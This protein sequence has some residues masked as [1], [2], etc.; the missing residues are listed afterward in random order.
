MAMVTTPVA[1]SIVAP[2]PFTA[3]VS[4]APAK[5]A[6]AATAT[7]AAPASAATSA[8]GATT[9]GAAWTIASAAVSAAALPAALVAVT[10]AARARPSS[11]AL[12]H[13]GEPVA[14]STTSPS[15]SQA[16]AR[17][18]AGVPRQAPGS[19]VR[20]ADAAFPGRTGEDRAATR[21]GASRWRA[22]GAAADRAAAASV[23]VT[24]TATP[25]EPVGVDGEAAGRGIDR[26][27]LAGDLEAQPR[28][29][30]PPRQFS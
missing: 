3:N 10:R 27:P 19:R 7:G 11:A 13:V 16:T 12:R 21:T 15:R 5:A 29:A 6:A 18:G 8:S 1:E 4:A 22:S 26:D 14:P 23:A 17:S 28:S 24:M 2:V 9:V 30:D 20:G 25:R